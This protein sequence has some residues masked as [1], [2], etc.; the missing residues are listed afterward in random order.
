MKRIQEEITRKDKK[1]EEKKKRKREEKEKRRRESGR[2]SL[3]FLPDRG[4]LYLLVHHNFGLLQQ[5][6][7]LREKV[8]LGKQNVYL[9]PNMGSPMFSFFLL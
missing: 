8:I 9:F 2:L 7:G 1:E 6:E 4:S 3:N 5:L